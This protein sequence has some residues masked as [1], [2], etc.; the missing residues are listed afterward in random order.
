MRQPI[1]MGGLAFSIPAL[2]SAGLEL[3][4]S[5][6]RVHVPRDLRKL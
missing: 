2:A 4:Q 6:L 5:L 1:K 3:A